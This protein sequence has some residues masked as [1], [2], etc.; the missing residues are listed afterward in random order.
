MGWSKPAKTEDFFTFL[1]KTIVI[2]IVVISAIICVSII[3]Y[4]WWQERK[5]KN[6]AQIGAQEVEDTDDAEE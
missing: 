3:V 6:A 4:D 2:A 5:A 1:A